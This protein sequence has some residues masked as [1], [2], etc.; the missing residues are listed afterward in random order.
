MGRIAAKTESDGVLMGLLERVRMAM[1]LSPWDVPMKELSDL[2]EPLDRQLARISR[3]NAARPWRPSTVA[4]ALGVPANLAA[5]TLI[6]N[7]M[8]IFTLEGYRNG[9]KVSN[10]ERPRLIVRPNPNTT[11]RDYLR[12]TGWSMAT[13]G[14]NWQWIGTRDADNLALSLFPVPSHEVTTEGDWLFPTVKWRNTVKTK[15][16]VAIFLTKELGEMRGKGPLQYCGAAISAAVESQEWAASFY[17]DGGIPS[18]VIHNEDELDA[19]EAEILRDAWANTPSN[20]PRVTSGPVSASLFGGPNE[21]SAQMLDARNF[22]AGE[23][24]RM[25]LIPGPLLEYARSGSSLTYTNVVTLM[26]QFLRQCLIPNYLEPLEQVMSDLLPRTWTAH[27]N[28]DEILRADIKT[29][30]E[31][32]E[33]AITKSGVLSVEEA[34]QMEGLAP[35]SVEYAP[36]PFAPPQAFPSTLPLQFSNQPTLRDLRCL[37]CGR[38]A[39]RIAGAA[40]IKCQRCGQ[41]VVAAA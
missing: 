7:T 41:M 18:V 28:V 29:R 1:S 38:L 20:M 2:T 16:M 19:G 33:S 34:R 5:V 35:G 32:Y 36:V 31:V 27:F 10:D 39:G 17:A 4:E 6:S 24:S 13:R 14:E 12:E 22:N 25:W 37:Q 3:Q 30:Y 11:M 15:D 8:G 40:E 9:E 23:A 21:S 26:D